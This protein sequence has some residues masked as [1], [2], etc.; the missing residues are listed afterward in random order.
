MFPS[1]WICRTGGWEFGVSRHSL[2]QKQQEA[3]YRAADRGRSYGRSCQ[4][5]RM[6]STVGC[7]SLGDT[8]VSTASATLLQAC[9]GDGLQ[10]AEHRLHSHPRRHCGTRDCCSSC[11][12]NS[13]QVRRVKS[14][15]VRTLPQPNPQRVDTLDT[16][17]EEVS[18]SSSPPLYRL[19]G[20]TIPEQ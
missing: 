6:A 13:R 3:N 14:G 19:D 4:P 18:G 20:I 11:R 7:P 1:F 10:H 12:W 9:R 17:H 8:D 15:T 5:D 16:C 2:G